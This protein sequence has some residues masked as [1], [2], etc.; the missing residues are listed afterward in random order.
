MKNFSILLVASYQFCTPVNTLGIPIAR[1]STPSVPNPLVERDPIQ[2]RIGTDKTA[3][4]SVMELS[5]GH[6]PQD[7]GDAAS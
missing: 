4:T 5:R 7:P 6:H 2:W 3:E 1:L